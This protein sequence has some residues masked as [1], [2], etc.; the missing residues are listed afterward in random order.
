[1][2]DPEFRTTIVLNLRYA[3][4]GK[5]KFTELKLERKRVMFF[6][7]QWVIVHPI[8]DAS[9]MRGLSV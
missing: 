1:M 9:R 5:R 4:T 8:D 7:L 2:S 6:P 3:A